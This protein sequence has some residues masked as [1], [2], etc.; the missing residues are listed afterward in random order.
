M[1]ARL[2][3]YKTLRLD[4]KKVAILRCYSDQRDTRSVLLKPR[5]RHLT[6]I[7]RFCELL[8]VSLSGVDI[9]LYYFRTPMHPGS[10]VV[11]QR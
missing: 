5:M 1:R 4:V 3:I 10:T 11:E 2:Q 6:S 8:K 7:S 9:L